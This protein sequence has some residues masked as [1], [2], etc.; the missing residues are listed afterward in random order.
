MHAGTEGGVSSP[1]NAA[2]AASAA[3]SSSE[4]SKLVS[5]DLLHDL[6]SPTGLRFQ[7]LDWRVHLP[8]LKALGLNILLNNVCTIPGHGAAIRDHARF[9]RGGNV[10]F[11]ACP[12]GCLCALGTEMGFQSDALM[13]FALRHQ[14]VAFRPGTISIFLCSVFIYY[15]YLFSNY[16]QILTSFFV[17]IRRRR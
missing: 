5:L 7:D 12:H 8:S 1:S 2:A 11:D 16:F 3:A 9:L 6:S 14:I 10:D 13:H 4:T 17:F 15:V